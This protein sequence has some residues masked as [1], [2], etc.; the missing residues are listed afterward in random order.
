MINYAH[1]GASEYAPENTMTSFC[2]G[3]EMGA[4]GIETDIQRTC[5]GVLVLSH[6]ATLKRT[7]GMDCRVCDRSWAELADIDVGLFKDP[8][9]KGERMVT[10]KDFLR[11]FGQKDLYFAI[12]IKQNGIEREVW[13]AIRPILPWARV[14]ITSFM[15]D[16]LLTLAK[17]PIKPRL[18]YLARSFSP[19]LLDRLKEQGIEE[20]CPAAGSLDEGMAEAVRARG[21]GLR[22]WGVSSEELMR[23][24]CALQVD[25]MTVNFPDKL[26]QYLKESSRPSNGRPK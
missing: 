1:R 4:N 18:G 25:G 17:E 22:A 11:Y 15:L 6:D 19:Q 23:R 14:T 7:A 26:T 5:D 24:M 16:S 20:Y 3:I 21:M 12:E 8:K 10:L 9:Y 13:E 2:M